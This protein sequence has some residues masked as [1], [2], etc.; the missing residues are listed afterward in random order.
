MLAAEVLNVSGLLL[1]LG[2]ARN[3]T[4]LIQVSWDGG[5]EVL[6]FL[7]FLSEYTAGRFSQSV[8]ERIVLAS[9]ELLDNA[10]RYRSLTRDVRYQLALDTSELIVAV[11]NATVPSRIEMLGAQLRKLERS[12]RDAYAAEFERSVQSGGARSMLGLARVR[13]EG[14][15]KLDI[16]VEGDHVTVF[17][18]CKR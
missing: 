1:G 13:H 6:G 14:G 11:A 16:A 15:M 7:G 4:S 12:P 10:V 5:G 3:A 8:S 18:R 17:A 9:N 2:L